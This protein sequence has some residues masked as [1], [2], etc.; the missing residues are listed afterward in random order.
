MSE[1]HALLGGPGYRV[2][3]TPVSVTE[4]ARAPYAPRAEPVLSVRRDGQVLLNAEAA[5]LLPRGATAA[6]LRYPVRARD[7]W[8][9]SCQAT[10]RCRLRPNG[11]GL[12]FRAPLASRELFAGQPPEVRHLQFWLERVAGGLYRLCPVTAN[13]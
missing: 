10:D 5:R 13:N 4:D 2:L 3:A 12:Y 6:E 9:F 7:S 11:R 1:P 8:H